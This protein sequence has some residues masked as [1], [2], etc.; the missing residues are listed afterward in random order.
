MTLDQHQL[1]GI[2]KFTVKILPT[3][4]FEEILL[5][6][7]YGKIGTAPARG[8]R[9]KVWWSHPQFRRVEAIYSPDGR[10]AITAYHVS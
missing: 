10:I 2:P 9:V 5:E 7:G 1:D 6:A 8:N 4:E 3:S